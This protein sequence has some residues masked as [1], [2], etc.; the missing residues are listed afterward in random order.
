MKLDQDT[1]II[2][3]H[4]IKRG[5][6]T[7]LSLPM[8]KL[9]DSTPL[10]MPVHII[11][12][13]KQGPCICVTAAIHGD[14]LNGIEIARKLLKQTSKK[15]IAGTLIV[16]PIVN[17]YGFL[18]QN[19]YLMDRRDLNR[20]FPGSEKGSLASRLAHVITSEVASHATIIID[21]HAGSHHRS[22]LP[23]IRTD[24][25]DPTCKEIAETFHVPVLVHSTIRDGSLRGYAKEQ[26][27]PCLLYEAGEANR[28]DQLSI[29]TGLKGI[30]HVMKYL[31]MLKTSKNI[32]KYTQCYVARH[33]YWVRA[34]QSGL[35]QP[36]KQLGKPVQEGEPIA[37]I[38]EP[39]TTK[40]KKICTP[41][42]GIIIGINKIPV[43][44]EG[45]A[46]FNI[47]RFKK[48]QPVA[49]N[50]SSWKEYLTEDYED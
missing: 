4:T 18:Y 13:K 48:V 37:T 22:N 12:G 46:L 26:N 30:I 39:T 25:D 40:E 43:V 34:P 15:I 27:I 23:H 6:A 11:R 49:E 14:E 33:T 3:G 16:I 7:T 47:A 1:L 2:N 28:L 19:R 41:I 50:I 32:I 20:C 31:H 9:Y 24:L 42:S 44:H 17:I 36:L 38:G 45:A 29:K 5:Q 10:H 21:L 8:P 35:F